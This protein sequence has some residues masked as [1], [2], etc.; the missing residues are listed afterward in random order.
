M[1]DPTAEQLLERLRE[2]GRIVSTGDLTEHQIAAARSAGRMFV[3]D[4][5]FG[6]V[7]LADPPKADRETLHPSVAHVLQFFTY[8][9]LPP[10]LGAVS[11]I[12][13]DVAERIATLPINAETTVA[14]RKILEAKDAAVRSV[15][16]READPS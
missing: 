6:Y 8:E 7:H 14:M 5:G 11:K 9:H 12:F 3:D 1:A 4:D 10:H 2:G 15:I 13:A 16:I